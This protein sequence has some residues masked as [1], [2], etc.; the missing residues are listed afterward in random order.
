M[1]LD[2]LIAQTDA[3]SWEDPTSHIETILPNTL[4]SETLPLVGYIISQK[5]HNNHSVNSALNKAWDFATP[6]SFAVICPNKFLLKFSKQEHID[7]ILKEVTWNVNGSLIILREWSPHATLEDLSFKHTQFWIQIHGLP[8]VNR[9]LKNAI[10]IGKGMGSVI[11]VEDP[12]GEHHTFK[13]FLRILVELDVN[14]PLKPGFE[15]E[16]EDG[17]P[18]WISL[19]YERLDIYCVK[20]GRIGHFESHCHAPPKDCNPGKYSISLHVNIF[21]NLPPPS[22]GAWGHAGGSSS[23]RPP[24]VTK[25]LSL[26][27]P[28][29]TPSIPNPQTTDNHAHLTPTILNPL[30]NLSLQPSDPD[31]LLTT[32]SS[33]LTSPLTA[34]NAK[35]GNPPPAAKNDLAPEKETTPR[36]PTP[37]TTLTKPKSGSI[38]I[39]LP[40]FNP[41]PKFT[42]PG[43]AQNKSHLA[44]PKNLPRHTKRPSTLTTLT[45]FSNPSETP[46]KEILHK[47]YPIPTPPPLSRSNQNTPLPPDPET[48]KTTNTPQKTPL[49]RKRKRIVGI[50]TTPL[51]KGHDINHHEELL[52]EEMD[53]SFQVSY[54]P[55]SSP[56]QDRLIL[57]ANRKY[58]Q[59]AS[60]HPQTSNT[61]SVSGDN[62]LSPKAP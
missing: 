52:A 33:N 46:A 26:A 12:S 24:P 57:K 47:N 39:E 43:K 4:N 34:L 41:G 15:L 18:T 6:F 16:R 29:T 37:P 11:K 10:A 21:S 53:T 60:P 38:S 42:A 59:V 17:K 56:N 9:T 55:T 45:N 35:P 23:K 2:A 51:K 19:K 32:P 44:H 27:T 22:S 7:R 36:P 5:N 1:D 13:S 49:S 40:I 62:V 50:Y 61:L 25:I 8:L 58:K 30:K 54:Y 20:C 28:Q 48:H 3:L 14:A 31:T